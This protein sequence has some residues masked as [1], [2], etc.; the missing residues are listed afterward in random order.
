MSEV[1]RYQQWQQ[2]SS[3][4]SNSSSISRRRRRRRLLI[5]CNVSTECGHRT[6]QVQCLNAINSHSNSNSIDE[7]A[8]DLGGRR[9]EP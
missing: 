2:Q 3:G 8:A 9:L 5:L 7:N 6:R 1:Q 4:G